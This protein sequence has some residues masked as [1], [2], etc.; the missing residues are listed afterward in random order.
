MGTEQK[1]FAKS[2]TK[3]HFDSGGIEDNIIIGLGTIGAHGSIDSFNPLRSYTNLQ[4][5]PAFFTGRMGE[6][7]AE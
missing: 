5:P 6:F 3:N 4:D 7:T 1:T 2:I